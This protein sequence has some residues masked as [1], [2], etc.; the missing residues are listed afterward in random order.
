MV[1]SLE[2]IELQVEATDTL[3][4]RHRGLI[5]TNTR[6]TFWQYRDQDKYLGAI[7]RDFSIVTP[8]GRS[9]LVLTEIASIGDTGR[10]QGCGSDRR[11]ATENASVRTKGAPVHQKGID[12]RPK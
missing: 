10:R 11:A 12:P 5:G 8:P 6:H 3:G 9:H 7:A 4:E 1:Y 2:K